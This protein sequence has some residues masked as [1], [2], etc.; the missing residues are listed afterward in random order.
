[1]EFLKEPDESQ[2]ILFTGLDGAGKTSIIM[3]LKRKISLY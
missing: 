3:A 2:K 1:M